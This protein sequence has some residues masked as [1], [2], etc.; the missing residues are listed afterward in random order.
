MIGSPGANF[1]NY[2]DMKILEALQIVAPVVVAVAVVVALV[3]LLGGWGLLL[4]SVV[5]G[6]LVR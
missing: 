2:S 1:K 6:A 5:V 3:L 4:L